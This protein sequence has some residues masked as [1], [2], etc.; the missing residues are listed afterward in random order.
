MI[1]IPVSGGDVVIVGI[2]EI[3]ERAIVYL[4][5]PECAAVPIRTNVS[6]VVMHNG[7]NIRAQVVVYPN[8]NSFADVGDESG[9]EIS[10]SPGC[11]RGHAEAPHHRRWH[12]S[13]IYL[14]GR[15][16]ICNVV[17]AGGDYIKPL[18]TCVVFIRDSRQRTWVHLCR[19][20]RK[21]QADRKGLH[22][23]AAIGTANAA[24]LAVTV[25]VLL[26]LLGLGA[27]LFLP[28]TL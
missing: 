28:G 15:L 13:R 3:L 10:L 27:I 14:D 26:L 5:R 20:R 18:R 25:M 17:I 21:G 24:A 9:S 23:R 22:R 19:C 1:V 4:L 6:A 11:D 2:D 16:A 12:A 7:G 8:I